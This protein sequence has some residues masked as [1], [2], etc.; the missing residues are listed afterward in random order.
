MNHNWDSSN[1]YFFKILNSNLILF[2][3]GVFDS[4]ITEN[5]RFRFSLYQT[6]HPIR[7]DEEKLKEFIGETQEGG[8]KQIGGSNSIELQLKEQL[9][10][11]NNKLAL[12]Q[13]KEEQLKL[14]RGGLRKTRRF[15]RKQK[16]GNLSS[17]LKQYAHKTELN[18]SKHQTN[19]TN[20]NISDT[21]SKS[22]EGGKL[23]KNTVEHFSKIQQLESE[24][25]NNKFETYKQ[26]EKTY[27][28]LVQLK[29][30]ELKKASESCL[31]KQLMHK[32]KNLSCE[33]N[34]LRQLQT[35]PTNNKIK[36]ACKSMPKPFEYKKKC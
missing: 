4:D 30:K 3:I 2:I 7:D 5:I 15:T 29:N 24:L 32:V 26:M 17:S 34:S 9:E 13:Q 18:Q 14:M 11:A 10:V 25:T 12:L 31:H 8:R 19:D 22:K 33:N 27:K 20:E 28:Q 36:C 1:I 35:D 6:L 23:D 16:G 21:N